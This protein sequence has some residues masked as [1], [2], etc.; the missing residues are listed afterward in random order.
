MIGQ[1]LFYNRESLI[2]FLVVMARG[3]DWRKGRID[4]TLK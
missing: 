2:I 1:S 3:T 4:E